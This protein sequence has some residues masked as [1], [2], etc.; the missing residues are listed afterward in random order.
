M[1][2]AP[3]VIGFRVYSSTVWWKSISQIDVN[4]KE[5]I[6]FFPKLRYDSTDYKPEDKDRVMFLYNAGHEVRPVL[7]QYLITY[8]GDRW[9]GTRIRQRDFILA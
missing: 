3:E 8:L 7:R 6:R 9:E 5:I 1:P 2:K 4:G